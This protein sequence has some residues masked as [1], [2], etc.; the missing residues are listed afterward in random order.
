MLALRND[1]YLYD[2]LFS[3]MSSFFSCKKTDAPINPPVKPVSEAKFTLDGKSFTV[4]E[5]NI[6][7]NISART[8][9][10]L[11]NVFAMQDKK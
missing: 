4:E 2:F 10:L 5:K 7:T 3:A 1:F 6:R 9:T 8:S 11:Q